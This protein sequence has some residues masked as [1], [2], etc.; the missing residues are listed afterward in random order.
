MFAVG[1]IGRIVAHRSGTSSSSGLDSG[2][3]S[4]NT[5]VHLLGDPQRGQ[6]A[7]AQVRFAGR[8]HAELTAALAAADYDVDTQHNWFS[9]TV[10]PRESSN[11]YV[12]PVR[13]AGE[14]ALVTGSTAGI[15]RA[16]AIEFARQG[17]ARRRHRTRSRHVAR[18]SS[19]RSRRSAV[20]R[21]S[22]RPT[23]RDEAACTDLVAAAAEAFGGLTVLVNNAAGGD[24]ADGRA[25]D[26]ATDA[27]E[28]I[29]RVDLTGAV[30]AV[31]APPCPTSSAM[32]AARSST[33][34]RGRPNARA[35]DSPRT[36]RRRAG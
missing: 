8:H 14:K 21:R 17:A 23:S 24:H 25:G 30:L 26:L 16:I 7:E 27:W 22:S 12:R 35:P 20:V 13:L 10:V 32:A 15:G 6:A 18:T 1:V 9:L 36:S 4:S 11:H 2:L 34:R 28:A 5:A 33:S 19:T 3:P 31:R 29:L